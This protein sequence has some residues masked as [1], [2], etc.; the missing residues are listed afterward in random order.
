MN[1]Q[2]INPVEHTLFSYERFFNNL[3]EKMEKRKSRNKSFELNKIKKP[4]L[5]NN[6]NNQSFNLINNNIP[7][8]IKSYQNNLKNNILTEN[9]NVKAYNNNQSIKIK[10]LL[11]KSPNHN[12]IRNKIYK[13]I[14]RSTFTNTGERLYEKGIKMA[15]LEC[16][17]IKELKDNL[18]N[19]KKE[20]YTFHPKINSNTTE[21]LEESKKFRTNYKDDK[22]LLNY[23][24]I[25]EKKMK[26]LKD[27]YKKEDFSFIPNFNLKSLKME[28]KKN[29]SR[30]ERINRMYN[31]KDNIQKKLKRIEIEMYQDCSFKPEFTD[32]SKGSL[33]NKSFD[34]RQKIYFSKS[35][36]KKNKLFQEANE[37]FD[38][39]TGQELFTPLINE[40]KNDSFNLSRRKDVFDY[41]YSY[42]EK[43]K[44]H[45]SKTQESLFNKKRSL[46]IDYSS[47]NIFNKKKYKTFEKIFNLFDSNNDGQITIHTMDISKVP[48]KIIT[49]LQPIIEEIKNSEEPIYKDDFIE[50]CYKLYKILNFDDKQI[51][52]RFPDDE[53]RIK[54][55]KELT[56]NFPF[57]PKIDKNSEK[58]SSYT[59][60]LNSSIN[61]TSEELKDSDS[62]YI[63][64]LK[65]AL[66][67]NSLS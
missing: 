65:H 41:L 4:N 40:N 57:K 25:I 16:R 11:K 51:I 33:I 13:N 48:K 32:Y 10:S 59:M 5:S 58:I 36:E 49:I 67:H 28:N 37:P 15:E 47:N 2:K 39:K 7:T 38:N 35:Q 30:E 19:D 50:G 21:I 44:M 55:I 24:D 31:S 29:L 23:R 66:S 56:P 22:S 12:K 46:S 42:A 53:N 18:L 17:R 52:M 8:E 61:K 27:K 45:K 62:S 3:K 20:I 64:Y 34:E 43:Y 63:N 14:Q 9:K 1:K 60:F 54:R 26:K 6:L